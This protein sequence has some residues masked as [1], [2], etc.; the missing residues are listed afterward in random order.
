MVRKHKVH[1]IYI[2]IYIPRVCTL[3]IICIFI[4]LHLLV[5]LTAEAEAEP[6]KKKRLQSRIRNGIMSIVVGNSTSPRSGAVVSPEEA[7]PESMGESYDYDASLIHPHLPSTQES[8]HEAVP[9][10]EEKK[11]R[12]K[13]T[14][15]K[16]TLLRRLSAS[17]PP[18]TRGQPRMDYRSRKTS[19]LVRRLSTSE[20]AKC[21]A[22][23]AISAARR[24]ASFTMSTSSMSHATTVSAFNA[25]HRVP[26]MP[27]RQQMNIS[28][29][30][31][32]TL[33]RSASVGTPAEAV[34]SVLR[35]RR[36]QQAE[37]QLAMQKNIVAHFDA[38]MELLEDSIDATFRSF[39]SRFLADLADRR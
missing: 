39:Q 13:T 22:D 21:E 10:G 20:K 37:E 26:S 29:D 19:P 12:K 23:I 14:K 4:W 25:V 34:E 17:K 32:N 24:R 1:H 15:A 3:Y 35:Q 36:G 2:I 33:A 8:K 28:A 7:I 16:K 5:L 27:G 6:Q 30:R 31:R 18:P 11:P 9:L 38:R